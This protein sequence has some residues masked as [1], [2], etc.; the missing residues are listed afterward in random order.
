MFWPC[1]FSAWDLESI[2]KFRDLILPTIALAGLA[3]VPSVAVASTFNVFVGYADNLRA[4]GFF[5]TT[6]LGDAGVVSQSSGAQS[7]DSGAIR[8]DNSGTTALH[9]TNFLVAMNGGSGATYGVWNALD[10]AVGGTGIFTQTVPYNFDSS[11]NSPNSFAPGGL[12]PTLAGA[13]GIGGCSSTS[14]LIATVPGLQAICAANRPIVSFDLNGTHF[15]FDDT[16]HILDTGWY[17]F[18]NQSPDGNESINWNAIG[19]GADRGGTSPV[20][21]PASLPMLLI[22]VAGLWLVGRRNKAA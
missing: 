2:M 18:V 20:P 8:I 11:D 10:I 6:W 22:G 3:A 21:L 1:S 19:S 9:I 13:N 12:A 4:S 7:F 5:P 16:G 14:A 17:D 15:S